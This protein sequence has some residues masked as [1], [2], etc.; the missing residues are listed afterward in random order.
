MERVEKL[1]DAMVIFGA[2]YRHE[3]VIDGERH[4]Q[5]IRPY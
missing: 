5:I 2:V 4:S 3:R 1:F